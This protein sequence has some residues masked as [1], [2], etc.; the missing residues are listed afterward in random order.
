[1]N[2]AEFPDFVRR[3]VQVR[4]APQ[5][6]PNLG[7]AVSLDR[8]TFLFSGVGEGESDLILSENVR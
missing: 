7:F 8:S 4:G 2:D 1:M 6:N 3:R 5:G